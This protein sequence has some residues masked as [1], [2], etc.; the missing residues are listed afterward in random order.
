MFTLRR[1]RSL[2][3]L[4]QRVTNTTD[5]LGSE[6]LKYN[7]WPLW[8]PDVY[9]IECQVAWSSDDDMFCWICYNEGHIIQDSNKKQVVLQ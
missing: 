1:A 4:I 6:S 8:A 9:C 7:G 2:R 3:R 5:R